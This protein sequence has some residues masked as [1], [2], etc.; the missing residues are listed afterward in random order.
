MTPYMKHF[1]SRLSVDTSASTGSLFHGCVFG[2]TFWSFSEL[3]M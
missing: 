3:R 1:N 2:N